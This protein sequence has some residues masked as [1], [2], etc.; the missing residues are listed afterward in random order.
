MY[1]F[2]ESFSFS[3]F[4]FFYKPVI[5]ILTLILEFKDNIF[6]LWIEIDLGIEKAIVLLNI[7]YTLSTVTSS[8][9]LLTASI[10]YFIP[11][12]FASCQEMKSLIRFTLRNRLLEV[13]KL[14]SMESIS[15]C[16]I[17]YFFVPTCFNVHMNPTLYRGQV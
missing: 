9:H 8:S 12:Q 17:F 6:K 7:L 11:E 3:T 4:P 14:R 13:T 5:F 1:L 10:N 16:G 15:P 2:T